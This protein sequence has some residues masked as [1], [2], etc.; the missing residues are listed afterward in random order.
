MAFGNLAS[1]V[2]NALK[3]TSSVVGSGVAQGGNVGKS[4][5]VA[6][7]STGTAIGGRNAL[8]STPVAPKIIH[9]GVTGVAPPKIIHPLPALAPIKPI[10]PVK[11]AAPTAPVGNT[12]LPPLDPTN[13]AAY[14]NDL[15]QQQSAYND[16]VAP[17]LALSQQIAQMQANLP[18]ALQA[19]KQ[20]E[21]LA[22][23]QATSGLAA[24][25]LFGSG[26]RDV[27]QATQATNYNNANTASQ[28]S[29]GAAAQAALQAQINQNTANA[30]YALNV[31]G[32]QQAASDAAA[33]YQ[34]AH[35]NDLPQVTGGVAPPP[36]AVAGTGTQAYARGFFTN[37]SGQHYF[38][39]ANGTFAPVA[40]IPAGAKTVDAPWVQAKAW[41]PAPAAKA[42]AVA[43]GASAISSGV[44]AVIKAKRN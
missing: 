19:N 43:S 44:S 3:K 26:A 35:A 15:T 18:G 8:G 23:D 36:P 14:Q 32:P 1:N 42:G 17:N 20:A 31:A 11:L 4:A 16:A 27:N 22:S 5:F 30:T 21:D 24:S 28:N 39:D 33:A 37:N 38:L 6:N 13:T 41:A 12:P 7:G 10:V 2:A 25:G 9:P 40:A 34:T 29:Y